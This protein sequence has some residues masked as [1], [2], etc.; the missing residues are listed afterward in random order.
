MPF[1]VL[2]LGLGVASLFALSAGEGTRLVGLLLVLVAA[3]SCW[4]IVAYFPGV[5][6]K[7]L[8]FG[9]AF[10]LSISLKKHLLFRPSHMGGAIGLRISITDVLVLLLLACLL[11]RIRPRQRISIEAD[12]S[13]LTAFGVYFAIAAISAVLGNDTQLGW[14]ELSAL[15]QAFVVFVFLVNYVNNAQRFRI[16]LVG[17]VMGLLL[18]S[19]VATVQLNHPEFFKLRFLG[20]ATEGDERISNGQ[21]D[22]PDEDR[23]TTTIAG[24]VQERPSG[25]LIHPNVL[26][27]YLALTVPLAIGAS[28]WISARWFQLLSAAA[29]LCSGVAAYLTLSRSGWAGCAGAGLASLILWRYSGAMK[30]SR[31][32]KVFFAMLAVAV[33]IGC[34]IKA[35]TIYLRL[36]ETADEALE[37]RSNL[38]AA[39]RNMIEAHPFLGVGLNSFETVVADYDSTT[40]SRIKQFPVHNIVLL[41]L[42]ETGVL[43][44]AA[45]LILWIV[46]LRRMFIATRRIPSAALRTVALLSTCGV[47]GFFIGDMSNF[48][49][50]VPIMTS[51]IWA[52]VALV[53]AAE[54]IGFADLG[55][56]TRGAGEHC[57]GEQPSGIHVRQDGG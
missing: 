14:F 46:V 52:Q 30:L 56:V 43:G 9:L 2:M 1:V 25:L 18:Q 40:M 10:T 54:R 39:A 45:F 35:E 51:L 23:G 5:T 27:L 50:R 36:T 12:T 42:S 29:V 15:L 24:E 19:A 20:A 37:F 41:E 13:I 28:F 48:V 17:C 55:F 47:V 53:L 32:K 16:F 7:V 31:G 11:F 4:P 57:N 21:I 26:A 49:Y 33:V 44:G 22:L 34:V 38:M 3:L 6:E 8:L